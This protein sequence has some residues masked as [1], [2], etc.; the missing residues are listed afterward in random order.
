MKREKIDKEIDI[1]SNEF[2]E[3]QE[4]LERYIQ[5]R[6]LPRP[7][8]TIVS[9]L[10]WTFIYL[11][12]SF[13]VAVA[14]IYACQIANYAD[15]M[16]FVTDNAAVTLVK[17]VLEE[18]TVQTHFHNIGTAANPN[19]VLNEVPSY[20]EELAKCKRK[21]RVIKGGSSA[22]CC[23]NGFMN[24]NTEVRF[25]LPTSGGMDAVQSLS[26]TNALIADVNGTWYTLSNLTLLTQNEEGLY[27]LG[28]INGIESEGSLAFVGVSFNET[29]VISAE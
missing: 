21:L 2:W 19:W 5:A 10:A 12:I 13:V 22:F 8:T 17:A 4:R 25:F 6:T 24:N 28:I 11:F 29:L 18:G 26:V 15:T 3:E 23:G 9:V 7:K 14:I 1:Y 16:F 27:L 20:T